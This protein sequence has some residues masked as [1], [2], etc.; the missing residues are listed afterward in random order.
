ML[1]HSHFKG[2]TRVK[3]DAC[4]A[5]GKYME[6]FIREGVARCIWAGSGEEGGGG[7]L[8]VEDLEKLAPQLLMDF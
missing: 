6:T 8:E 7:M 4:A 3:K 5:I 2:E 1:L